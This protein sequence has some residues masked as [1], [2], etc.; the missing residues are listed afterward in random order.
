MAGA[1]AATAAGA[2]ASHAGLITV[3]LSNNYI[4][5]AGGN[6]LNADLTRDGN[7]DVIITGADYSLFY[8]TN[9]GHMYTNLRATVSL[10]GVLARAFHASNPLQYVRLGSR[11]TYQSGPFSVSLNGSIPISFKDLHINNGVLTKGSLNVTAFSGIG[12][13]EV[14]LTSFTYNVPDKV[15]DNGSSLAL[16]ALGAGGVLAL[17]RWRATQNAS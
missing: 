3:N 12:T 16:L 15:P 17:R 6:H 7:A 4:S 14:Q 5:G 13:S 1:T 9:S 8:P 11:T 2:T 10:N